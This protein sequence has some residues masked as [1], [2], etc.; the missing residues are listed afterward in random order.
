MNI[1]IFIAFMRVGFLGF[2]GGPTMLPLIYDETVN[3][4]KWMTDHEF[5]NVLAIGNTLPGPIATKMAGYI[6]YKTSGYTGMLSAI[7]AI[8][9]P[10]VIVMI[11][12]LSL[13]NEYRDEAWVSGIA[14]GVVPVVTWMLTKLTLD[15]F[16]KGYRSIGLITTIT[17]CIVAFIAIQILNIHPAII[18]L[19]I[20]LTA[21]L[22]PLHSKEVK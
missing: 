20:L 3:R 8:S 11:F 2:G 5:S 19:V 10:L 12:G 17:M 22:K 1:D 6:G 9:I 7:T 4:H 21:L 18:I 15:F 13:L 14:K 16:S